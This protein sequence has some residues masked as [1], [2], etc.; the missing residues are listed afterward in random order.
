MKF[1]IKCD[2]I[3]DGWNYD[4]CVLCKR[5]R[6]NIR[7]LDWKCSLNNENAAKRREFY[8]LWGLE[9]LRGRGYNLSEDEITI[10]YV[11]K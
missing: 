1:N 10:E 6:T 4:S 3:A 5:F 11:G 2:R 8:V 7:P 9:F